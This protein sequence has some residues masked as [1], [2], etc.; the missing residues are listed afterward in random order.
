MT[1]HVS[2][3]DGLGKLLTVRFVTTVVLDF[4]VKIE[5]S[6]GTVDLLAILVG[7]DELP[8]DLFCGATI[9]FFAI[10]SL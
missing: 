4:D 6:L 10:W 1:L 2:Q 5:W 9:V 3:N 7:T 8:I